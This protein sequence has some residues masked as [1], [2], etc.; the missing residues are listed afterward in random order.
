MFNSKLAGV[1]CALLAAGGVAAQTVP[2]F[3]P[4][5]APTE[6]VWNAYFTSKQDVASSQRQA[7][8]QFCIV[9]DSIAANGGTSGSSNG[10]GYARSGYGFTTWFTALLGEKINLDPAYN[11][12]VGGTYTSQ[13]TATVPAA[14]KLSC[15]W[16]IYQGSTNNIQYETSLSQT[17][18]DLTSAF[19]Q[20][21][22]AGKKLI[23]VTPFPR[24]AATITG[25]G[26]NLAYGQGFYDSVARFERRFAQNNPGVLVF[27]PRSQ[28]AIASASTGDYLTNMSPDGTHQSAYG[29]QLVG[30]ALVNLVSPFLGTDQGPL[31]TDPL[32]TYSASN[33]VTGNM[34]SNGLFTT[35]TGGTA[36]SSTASQ[37]TGI[38]PSAWALS[39]VGAASYTGSAAISITSRSDNNPGS[40]LTLTIS[41]L[42]GGTNHDYFY[43]GNGFQ[44]SYL[45]VTNG[46]LAVGDIV[47]SGCEFQVSNT[48]GIRSIG[49]T[50]YTVDGNGGGLTTQI[51]GATDTNGVEA[52]GGGNYYWP[53]GTYNMVLR[54]PPYALP[55]ALG[56]GTRYI[57][58]QPRIE[59]DTTVSGGALATVNMGRCWIRK[60]NY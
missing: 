41:S 39:F 28:A 55:P 57:T 7:G 34:L 9:G 11:L 59:L 56:S 1:L 20:I 25:L 18:T 5:S 43:L 12:G 47:D 2:P 17:E 23:I 54:V 10:S 60:T 35:S 38:A 14:L 15:Q 31:Q 21:L 26:V 49:I 53:T 52:S 32:D 16:V 27:D 6:A 46:T 37:V 29:A 44:F 3:D 48:R 13:I 30:Q 45:G 42:S 22:A 24:N 33:N 8:Q 50:N 51:M 58:F 40:W 19:T 36:F 4:G